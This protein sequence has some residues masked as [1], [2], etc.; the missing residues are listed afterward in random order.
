MSDPQKIRYI[1][2]DFDGVIADTEPFNAKYL[3]KA[4]AKYGIF[5]TEEEHHSLIGTSGWTGVQKFLDSA[6]PPVK[7]E[8]FLVERRKVGNSYEDPDVLPSPGLI[9]LLLK[10][11]TLNISTAIVS[12]T[13]SA[14]IQ[15]AVKRMGLQSLFDLYI[16]GDMVTKK[17]PDPEPYLM[18][19]NRL[20]ARPKECLIIEDSPIGIHSAKASGAKV[21]AY[22]G[23]SVMQDTSEADY[24]LNAFSDFFNLCKCSGI[25][26]I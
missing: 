15:T 19:M 7:L 5:L 1:L 26:I 14:Y 11:R 12:S 2:F 17:K 6:N 20:S 22:C 3:A 9:D 13:S 24:Q 25:S 4:L 10:I 8:D 23:S 16:C 21:I 18:A